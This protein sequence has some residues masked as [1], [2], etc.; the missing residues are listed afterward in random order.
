MMII[1]PLIIAVVV[2][3]VVII[4][5]DDWK[6]LSWKK[7][8]NLNLKFK[9]IQK[10]NCRHVFYLMETSYP[11]RT[12]PCLGHI[13]TSMFLDTAFSTDSVCITFHS[14]QLIMF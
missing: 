9:K 2:V 13:H 6:L 1:L 3:V 10:R 7:S 14:R 12:K 11:E 4:S 8:T 5:K